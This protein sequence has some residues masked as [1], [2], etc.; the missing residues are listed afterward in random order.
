MKTLTVQPADDGK[1]L[2]RWMKT[3]VP[4]LSLGLTQKYLRL[5]RVK[6]DG[7]PARGEERLRAGACV[8]L[9]IEDEFFEL[10][11]KPDALPDGEEKRA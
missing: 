2:D 4:G 10:R 5:K 11:E 7:K 9:Y 1:R 6:V 8:N 3:N